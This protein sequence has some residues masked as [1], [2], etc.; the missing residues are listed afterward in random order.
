MLLLLPLFKTLRRVQPAN[1]RVSSPRRPTNVASH[2]KHDT[3]GVSQLAEN[4]PE[5]G[6]LELGGVVK[7]QKPQDP[8]AP[9]ESDSCRQHPL[10]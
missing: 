4:Y 7:N 9:T 8:K 5:T 3:Y 1:F 2:S 6:T 10:K